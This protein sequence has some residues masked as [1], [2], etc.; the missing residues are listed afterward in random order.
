MNNT[1]LN[2]RAMLRHL[3][4]VGAAS[5]P[6]ALHAG[7]D[8]TGGDPLNSMQWPGLRQKYLGDAPMRF[9]NEVIVTGPAFADDAM[10]VPML[11]DARALASVGGGIE[12]IDVVSDRNP[13]REVLSFEP[14]LALPMLAFRF[15]M[16]QAS[17]V[18]AMVKTR[19]GQWHVGSAWVQAAGGGC[20]VPGA[21]RADGS[22]SRTLNQVQT[23][24]FSNV[25]AGSQ[26]LRLRIMHPMDTG[27]VA[28]I[29][30]F[31]VE[32]LQLADDAGRVWW[33]LALHEP[34][35]ENPLLTFEL[36][37]RPGSPLHL[38]GRD[39]NGN[40]ISAEVAA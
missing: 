21:T 10:S 29:P 15:R 23:K 12:R 7:D 40:P 20:T 1:R 6:L 31:Y 26:R 38:T 5:L 39:N 34:V 19:D 17:P 18:R 8:P 25:L 9:S 4:A 14:L 35:S 36:P 30:A 37:Q 28:G 2:R 32:N 22:W 27:L 13:I 33:R 3:G 16:E 11:I 24:F